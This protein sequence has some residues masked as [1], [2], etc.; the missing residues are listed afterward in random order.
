M[1]DSLWMLKGFYLPAAVGRHGP[2]V[3]RVITRDGRTEQKEKVK[4]SIWSSLTS[5]TGDSV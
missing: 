5:V 3:W 2:K 1:S 4:L